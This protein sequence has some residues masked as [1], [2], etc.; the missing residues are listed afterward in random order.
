MADRVN[1]ALLCLFLSLTRPVNTSSIYTSSDGSVTFAL[2]VAQNTNDLFFQIKGTSG[3]AWVAVGTGSE[4]QGSQMFM[5]YTSADGNSEGYWKHSTIVPTNN[6]RRSHFKF[7]I[8]N[9]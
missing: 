1:P 3:A 8:G 7:P 4:M 5:A 9:R 2:S 6:G